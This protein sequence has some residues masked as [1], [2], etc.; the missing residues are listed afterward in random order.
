MRPLA[1]LALLLPGCSPAQTWEKVLAPGVVY[2]NEVR[3]DPPLVIH[4]VRVR[5]GAEGVKLRPVLANDK[6][7]DAVTED[8]R[9]KLTEIAR[10][11][12]AIAAVNGDFFPWT[13]DPLGLMVSDGEIFSRPYPGRSVLA[14][15]GPAAQIA[16]AVWSCSVALPSGEV[17]LS[18]LNEQLGAEGAVLVTPAGGKLLAKVP[19]TVVVLSYEGS[20]A[21]TQKVEASVTTVLSGTSELPVRQGQLALGASGK[22][23]ESFAQLKRGDKVTI[24]MQTKGIDWDR[25]KFAIGGGPAIVTGGDPLIAWESEGL[26]SSFASDRHPRT[27][28]GVTAQ[29]DMWIVVV[30]GRQAQ[31]RGATLFEL[32]KIAAGLGCVEA[33]NLDGGGSSELTIGQSVVNRPSDGAERPIANALVVTAPFASL[34]GTYVIAG[35]EEVALGT[36]ADYRVL[37]RE[38]EIPGASVVWSAEGAAWV[39]QGGRLRPIQTGEAI[40]RAW[41]GGKVV[42]KR[43]RIVS[44]TP[45]KSKG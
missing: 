43:V 41:I 18:G 1:F 10:Q 26:S 38:V 19:S 42:E 37:D 32:S 13:G 29:G 22:V 3:F 40:V 24:A 5:A 31:S 20:L 44:R 7:F 28:V 35:R 21:P 45:S 16:R 36:G 14:W 15:G 12:S 33:L 39:D 23:A 11:T 4:A 25:Q 30:D 8:G 2:R 34:D 9:A 27:A 6:V 17:A